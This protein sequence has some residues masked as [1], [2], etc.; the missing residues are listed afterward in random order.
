MKLST[1]GR[2]AVRA[3]FDLAQHYDGGLVMVKDVAIRQGISERYLEHL[4]LSLKKAGLVNSLRGARGGFVLSRP[5]AEIKLLEIV[6]ISEGPTA[7]VDCV[8][9]AGICPRSPKCVTRDVWL[10]VQ[11][12]IDGVLSSQTLQ[13]LIKRQQ[14]KV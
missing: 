5:P 13:D 11:S 10:E 6:R 8:D 7:L 1:K 3:M 12:A 4:F 9:N 14:I 2:Y